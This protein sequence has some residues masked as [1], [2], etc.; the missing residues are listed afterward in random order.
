MKVRSSECNLKKKKLRI[1]GTYRPEDG[2]DMFF[3]ND[4]LS[5][6]YTMLQHAYHFQIL[7]P[8]KDIMIS[9]AIKYYLFFHQA[10]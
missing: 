5:P 9:N 3:R 7:S 6:N 10:L 1:G 2:G 4:G 8:K